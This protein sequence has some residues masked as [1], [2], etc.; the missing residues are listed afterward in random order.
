MGRSL[1]NRMNH[2]LNM[3]IRRSQKFIWAPCAQL[4]SLA[5]ISIRFRMVKFLDP[6]LNRTKISWNLPTP[7]QTAMISVA[8][9]HPDPACQFDA[10]PDSSFQIKAQ[11]FEKCLKRLVFHTF[12]LVVCKLMRIRTRIRIQLITL[13]LI[14]IQLITL[15][16]FW[17]LLFNLMRIRNRNTGVKGVDTFNK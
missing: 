9:P 2:R 7:Q 14:R 15:M 17:I 12:W 10:D 16:R 11:N 5:Q 1:G 6:F 3:E 4:Y 13:M 8:D